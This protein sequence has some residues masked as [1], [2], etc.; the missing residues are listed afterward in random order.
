MTRT[1]V[2]DTRGAQAL[3]TSQID[4]LRAMLEQQRS[5]R[6]DQLRALRQA[7]ASEISRSLTIGARA[8]LRD[9]L[10]ALRR[11][12]EGR[13]GRCRSCDTRLPIER[14]EVLPQVGRCMSCQQHD[15]LPSA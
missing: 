2:P 6:L 13:Y 1:T 14:L 4:D 5:F 11:M 3:T 12:D 15:E 9:V 7:D 8:A 10:D